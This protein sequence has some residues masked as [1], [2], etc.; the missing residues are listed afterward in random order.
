MMCLI[1]HSGS[2]YL[3]RYECGHHFH[4]SCLEKWCQSSGCYNKKI[5][6]N[7]KEKTLED[8]C[9]FQ[10]I[11]EC[12]YCSKIITLYKHTNINYSYLQF[13]NHISY[14]LCKFNDLRD[15]L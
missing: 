11:L 3:P 15:I 1:C 14:L 13:H 12:P 9:N 4:A 2:K 10:T 7:T 8:I 5:K 6:R